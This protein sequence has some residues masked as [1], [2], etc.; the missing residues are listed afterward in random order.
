VISS[1]GEFELIE[2]ITAYL[3]VVAPASLRI[4]IGDD[5]AA[6][7]PT[8]GTLTV[9]TTDALVE[10]VHF[11]TGTTGWADLGWKAMAEN[12]SDVAAM[13]CQPRYA[14]LALG[15]PQDRQV[16]EIEELY[17]GIAECAAAYGF[18]LVGGDVVRAP[19]VVINVTMVGESL[20]VDGGRRPLLERSAARVGD[21]VAVTGPLGGSAAG[22]RLLSA[23]QSPES[24]VR[25]PNDSMRAVLCEAHRRPIPR[26]AAGLALVEAGVRCAIDVSDGLV[27]DVGH[28][29]ERSTVAVEL[30]AER[31]PLFPEANAVFGTEALDL[32]LS[33]GEDYEL[34]CAAPEA[35]L[36]RANALLQQRGQR[37][38][39]P[40][41]AVVS[42]EGSQAE[43]RVRL[44]DGTFRPLDVRGYQHFGNAP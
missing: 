19:T 42:A 16:A 11:D 25:S 4:G 18:A 34:V 37:P 3:G 5:A 13:G 12:V 22:L 8:P 38:L 39:I 15:L 14:L 21:V 2:R 20:P 26:V 30:A 24:G 27:A 44:A 43:V 17:R 9:A 29:C 31:V 6:W 41:G 32:A 33:G 28:I 35:T 10:G 40:I 23:A 36:A 7:A 1:L